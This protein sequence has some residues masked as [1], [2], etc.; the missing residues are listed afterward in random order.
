MINCE[1]CQARL[2]HHVY[3]LLEDAERQAI[4]QHLTGCPGCRAALAKARKQDVARI[5]E[6]IRQID[7]QL[8]DDLLKVKQSYDSRQV[9]FTV[10][11]PKGLQA[12]GPNAIRIDAQ[13]KPDAKAAK[14]RMFAQVVDEKSKLE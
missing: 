8:H 10:Q 1:S 9:Q 11:H 7:A 14:F 2:L 4:A 3:G 6:Q 12:G 13:R 5:E